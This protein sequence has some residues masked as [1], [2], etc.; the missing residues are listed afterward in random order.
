MKTQF[1]PILLVLCTIAVSCKNKASNEQ[2]E[3][4][5]RVVAIDETNC[6]IASKGRDTVFII[7]H[8]VGQSITGKLNFMAYESDSRIGTVTSGKMNGDT[9]FAQYISAQEGMESDC[10][11]ALLKKESTYI[12]SN[13]FYGSE[14]YQFNTDDTKGTFKDKR[15]IK[16]DG[17]VLKTRHFRFHLCA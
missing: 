9:L 16:F 11:I 7:L 2:T 8:Q 13:D 1:L 6:Y 12:L 5:D 10:E 15:H 17:V 4:K 14:N 3:N